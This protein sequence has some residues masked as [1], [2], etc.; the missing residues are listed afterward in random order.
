MTEWLPEAKPN[1]FLHVA[2]RAIDNIGH[3]IDLDRINAQPFIRI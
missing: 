2:N 1:Y 3:P